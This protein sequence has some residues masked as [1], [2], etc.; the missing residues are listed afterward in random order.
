MIQTRGMN[1]NIIEI[2]LYL[3]NS[4]LLKKRSAINRIGI[5]LIPKNNS[6]ASIIFFGLSNIKIDIKKR[7]G[8]IESVGIKFN[9]FIILYQVGFSL[10][11]ESFILSV[12]SMF[13]ISCQSMQLLFQVQ[14]LL[15]RKSCLCK[16]KLFY[17]FSISRKYLRQIPLKSNT[18]LF[19]LL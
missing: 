11:A 15:V 16:S 5:P 8:Q 3:S 6:Q 17:C 14:S 7:I 19:L 9:N 10:F 4:R 13:F 18:K 12:I 2:Y 1:D